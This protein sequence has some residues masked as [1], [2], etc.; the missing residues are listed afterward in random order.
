[1]KENIHRVTYNTQKQMAELHMEDG[2]VRTVPMTEEEWVNMLK[3]DIVENFRR[4]LD[5]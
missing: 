4:L 1:M 2:E 5:E 3:G